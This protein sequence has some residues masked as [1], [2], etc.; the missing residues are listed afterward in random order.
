MKHSNRRNR[1]DGAANRRRAFLQR[2]AGVDVAPGE[3][4]Q[5]IVA[6]DSDCP[7]LLGGVCACTPDVSVKRSDAR[8][9]DVASDGSVS[10]AAVP[11]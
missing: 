5:V 3:V 6:H 11:S 7:A 4:A 8:V 10:D 1:K 9:Q 2:V